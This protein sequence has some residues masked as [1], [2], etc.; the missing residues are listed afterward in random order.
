MPLNLV[1]LD[2]PGAGTEVPVGDGVMIGRDASAGLFLESLH[3]SRRHAE[4]RPVGSA[5]IEVIDL[6]STH[7]T[8]VG[9]REIA[10]P[11][12]L[13]L[14]EQIII[15]PSRLA[16]IE[17]DAPAP[18][19][20]DPDDPEATGVIALDPDPTDP[21]EAEPAPEVTDDNYRDTTAATRLVADPDYRPGAP[22]AD[23][24]PA[25]AFTEADTDETRVIRPAHPDPPT[26]SDP[27]TPVQPIRPPAPRRAGDRQWAPAPPPAQTGAERFNFPAAIAFVLG[28]AALLVALGPPGGLYAALVMAIAA[29]AFGSTGKRWVDKDKADGLRGLALAGQL[30]AVVAMIAS[31]ILIALLLVSNA[32]L[33]TGLEDFDDIINQ[34]DDDL[35]DRLRQEIESRL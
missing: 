7:G 12:R 21:P 11:T 19:P 4:V 22:A 25:T 17:V 35:I 27:I 15:G 33:D 10:S 5:G 24:T 2:G 1:V 8:I 18:R 34:L 9:G 30:F 31:T 6:G 20:D 3:V 29:I 23:H 32:L 14:D 26:P 13:A 16:V 28:P